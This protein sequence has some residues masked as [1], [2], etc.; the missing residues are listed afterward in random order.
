MGYLNMGTDLISEQDQTDHEPLH[1]YLCID[2]YSV[3][4]PHVKIPPCSDTISMSCL[5]T[6]HVHTF[7]PLT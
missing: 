2:H 6:P 1:G 7:W 3:K 4:I 5:D